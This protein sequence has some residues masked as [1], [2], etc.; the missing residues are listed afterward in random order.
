MVH[1]VPATPP[2]K[3]A[4]HVHLLS[5]KLRCLPNL[6]H[7]ADE[8]LQGWIHTRRHF[9][10]KMLD[11]ECELQIH[12]WCHLGVRMLGSEP[13][14]WRAQIRGFVKLNPICSDSYLVAY[15]CEDVGLWARALE[16]RFARMAFRNFYDSCKAA[17]AQIYSCSISREVS[18]QMEQTNA[19]LCSFE[20]DVQTLCVVKGKQI[21]SGVKFL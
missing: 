14:L 9:G 19:F 3:Y 17:L 16:W 10:A 13:E 6:S 7:L 5:R 15:W 4:D 8:G 2:S 20:I 18:S 11:F 12:T 21:W 1:K